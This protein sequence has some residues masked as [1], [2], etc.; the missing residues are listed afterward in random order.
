[1][2]NNHKSEII[3]KGSRF[4]GLGDYL[5][6][7]AIQSGSVAMSLFFQQADKER[8]RLDDIGSM[9]DSTQVLLDVYPE[10]VQVTTDDSGDE[11]KRLELQATQELFGGGN[12]PTNP[13]QDDLLIEL[14]NVVFEYITGQHGS[15]KTRIHCEYG[16]DMSRVNGPTSHSKLI[17]KQTLTIEV[18]H[19][20]PQ[21][22]TYRRGKV[23]S[24]RP[25][26]FYGR[27]DDGYSY[28]IA[29]PGKPTRLSSKVASS[30]IS[31]P[32]F[33]PSMLIQKKGI[34]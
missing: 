12:L 8:K 29:Y 19:S 28:S 26:N 6:T 4:R 34:Y 14:P 23:V 20:R 30:L 7:I 22:A 33:Q 17:T 10:Y 25:D 9:L 1:M 32:M 15:K 31:S 2:K 24:S 16:Q 3:D 27:Q 13:G 21:E 18:D 5:R 11:V